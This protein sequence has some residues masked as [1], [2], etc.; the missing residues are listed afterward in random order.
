MISLNE[1]STFIFDK[2]PQK[3][4]P[5]NQKLTINLFPDNNTIDNNNPP[6]A[7]KIPGVY[8]S[9]KSIELN[10]SGEATP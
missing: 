6:S 5:L 2:S 7:S 9:K 4:T 3:G 1:K 8:T 10:K